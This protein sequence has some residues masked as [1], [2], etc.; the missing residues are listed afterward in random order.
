MRIVL[1]GDMGGHFLEMWS[2]LV[3]LGMDAQ[4]CKLPKDMHVVQVGDLVHRGPD[5]AQAIAFVER[6]LKTGQ[7]TQHIGN[8]EALHLGLADFPWPEELTKA[9]EDK[10]QSWWQSGQMV[11]SSAF[12]TDE[13][14]DIFVSHAGLTA[15]LWSK[16]NKPSNAQDTVAKVQQNLQKRAIWETGLMY[17]GAAKHS[18]GLIWAEE[19]GEVLRSWQRYRDNGWVAEMPFSMVHGHSSFYW[20]DR[21][22]LRIDPSPAEVMIDAQ[23]RHSWTKLGERFLVGIDPGFDANARQWKPLVLHG[24]KLA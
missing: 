18:A 11:V 22:L 3:E 9:D 23:A 4:T 21:Q 13:I 8:H 7:W 5:N 19:G 24:E 15:G 16:L 14:G 6:Q 1:L 2:A 12:S 17:D 10:L 20:W